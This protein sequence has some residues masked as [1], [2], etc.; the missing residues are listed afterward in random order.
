MIQAYTCDKMFPQDLSYPG[1]SQTYAC[2]CNE[3]DYH[4]MPQINFEVTDSSYQFN[5]NP[6]QYMFLPY[7][8]YTE[9]IVS[10]C[11]LGLLEST[12][13]LTNGAS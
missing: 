3:G 7:L 8:N 9:P 11:V 2:Y 1:F 4:S 6:G 13:K 10:L 5:L 12:K